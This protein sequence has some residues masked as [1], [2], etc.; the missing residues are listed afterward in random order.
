MGRK[1]EALNLNAPSSRACAMGKGSDEKANREKS[2]FHVKFI[3]ITNNKNVVEI[4]K[5]ITVFRLR[6]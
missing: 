2:K 3:K 5:Q 6:F 1:S 4:H